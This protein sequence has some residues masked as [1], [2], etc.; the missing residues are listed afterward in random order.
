MLV[1]TSAIVAIMLEEPDAETLAER[2]SAAGTV[3]TTVVNAF[4][5]ALSV[6]KVIEDH[7]LAAE[8][9]PQFL[10]SAGIEMVGIDADLYPEITDAYARFG[11]GTGHPA[12]LNFGDCFSYAAAKRLRVPLLYR[13]EDF[14]QTDL[15]SVE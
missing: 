14:A 7:P 13:G 9:V 11:K 3:S 5:A 4:E 2:V 8:L 15:K 6:G 12:K 1:E 10:K